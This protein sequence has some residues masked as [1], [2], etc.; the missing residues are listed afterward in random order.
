MHAMPTV[1]ASTGGSKDS[2]V[3]LYSGNRRVIFIYFIRALNQNKFTS[4]T[5]LLINMFLKLCAW[6]RSAVLAIHVHTYIHIFVHAYA[7]L[8]K[9]SSL[10]CVMRLMRLMRLEKTNRSWVLICFAFFL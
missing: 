2:H 4:L 7:K 10:T 3:K 5:S 8:G 1:T 9:F 6:K